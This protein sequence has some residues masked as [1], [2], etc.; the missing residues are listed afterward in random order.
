MQRGERLATPRL[1]RAARSRSVKWSDGRGCRDRA[2]CRRAK[3]A[4]ALEVSDRRRV[5]RRYRAAAASH[6]PHCGFR[7]AAAARAQSRRSQSSLLSLTATSASVPAGR[8]RV[9]GQ[10]RRPGWRRRQRSAPR[11]VTSVISTGFSPQP[12]RGEGGR[13][14]PGLVEDEK[15]A[16][17][18][19]VRQISDRAGPPVSVH[20]QEPCGRSPS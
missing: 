6:P 1:S 14:A 3:I 4:D 5:G 15:V 11:S 8:E 10:E 9:A 18:E 2:L 16:G 13:L 20:H 17:I 12:P 7:D 19:Q